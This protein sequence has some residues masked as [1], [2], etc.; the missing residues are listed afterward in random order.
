MQS[1]HCQG[2]LQTPCWASSLPTHTALVQP[3]GPRAVAPWAL[4][5]AAQCRAGSQCHPA[6]PTGASSCPVLSPWLREPDV[7]AQGKRDRRGSP[8]P[9]PH[10]RQL[11]PCP[12]GISSA[13]PLAPALPPPMKPPA[14]AA[15]PLLLRV[16]LPKQGQWL[17]APG[18]PAF[19]SSTCICAWGLWGH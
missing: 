7:L 3:L 1:Q 11:G 6:E 19:S 17:V 2:S 4:E 16:L 9:C 5:P 12:C 15:P 14:H 10:C 13:R 18:P 8:G